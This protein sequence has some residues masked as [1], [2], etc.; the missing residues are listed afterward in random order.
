MYVEKNTYMIGHV[1]NIQKGLDHYSILNTD[2]GFSY[3]L[4]LIFTRKRHLCEEYKPL[5]DFN[6][7][8]ALYESL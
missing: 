1:N 3:F 2:V 7:K 5:S 8:K 4:V 6:N